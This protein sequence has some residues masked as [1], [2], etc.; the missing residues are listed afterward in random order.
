MIHAPLGKALAVAVIAAMTSAAAPKNIILF[1]GDGMGASQL[2]T[3]RY[4]KDNM[5]I[6]RCPVGGLMTT[7]SADH[8]VTDS[9][10][11][12]TALATGFR[13]ANGM[14]GQAPDGSPL[15]TALEVAEEQGKATGLVATSSI[16][17]ATPASFSAH[18]ASRKMEPEIAAQIAAQEIEVLLGGGRGFFIPASEAGS[19]RK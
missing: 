6:A 3:A 19:K 15:K 13:T 16:T 9:A 11:S 17:H 18:V 10:A 2:T 12:G 8:F 7:H 14:I 4:A 5:E 1:I